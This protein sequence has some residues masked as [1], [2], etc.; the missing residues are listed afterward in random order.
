MTLHNPSA[1]RPLQWLDLNELPT[2]LRLADALAAAGL[3]PPIFR[4]VRVVRSI[5]LPRLLPRRLRM[6]LRLGHTQQAQ[7]EPDFNPG[8]ED[9]C[10]GARDVCRCGPTRGC[11]LFGQQLPLISRQGL[12]LDS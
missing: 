9:P 6:N 11:G 12:V 5:H 1:L 8:W 4:N 7:A 3:G 2:S 10:F